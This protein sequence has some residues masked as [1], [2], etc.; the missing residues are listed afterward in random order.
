MQNE[1]SETPRNKLAERRRQIVDNLGEKAYRDAFVRQSIEMGLPFQIR[2]MRKDRRISQAQLGKRLNTRQSV[3]S[4]LES[5]GY[6]SFSL[7]TLLDLASHFD[8]GLLVSFVPFS[9]LASRVSGLTPASHLVP[10]FSMDKMLGDSAADA[11]ENVSLLSQTTETTKP[12]MLGGVVGSALVN[13]QLKKS[14]NSAPI[15]IEDSAYAA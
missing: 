1:S 3:V 11:G 8:V 13:V 12:R 15:P 7:S 4:R 6:G 10:S 14:G 2:A 9:E 5:P